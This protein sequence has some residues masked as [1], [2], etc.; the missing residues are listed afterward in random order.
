MPDQEKIPV[1]TSHHQPTQRTVNL[2]VYLLSLVIVFGIGGYLGYIYTPKPNYTIKGA[3]PEQA[4]EYGNV[5][6]E[7]EA[8]PEYLTQDVDF[9][10][11]WDVWDLINSKYYDKNV[12]QT[13]LFYGA[14]AGLVNSLGDPHTVFMT[15]QD[16]DS[17]E[18]ELQGHFEGIGAEIGIRNEQLSVISPLPDHP[19]I[20]AGLRA[21][22]LILQIDGEDTQG[23]SLHEA[24]SKIRGPKGTEVVLTIYRQGLTQPQDYAITRQEINVKSLTLEYQD[25]VGVIKIRQF[26]GDTVPLLNDAILDV[27]SRSDVKGLIVDLRNNPGGYLQAAIEVAGEWI[28]GQT[29]VVEKDRVGNELKHRSNRPARLDNYPTIVLINAG[30]ASGSE[31]LAGAL[32]D[33]G[34]C[35]VVGE[36]S[37]GKGSVQELIYLDN[38]ASVKLTVAKWFTPNGRSIEGNGIQPDFVIEMSEEDYN[39]FQDPQMVKALELLSQ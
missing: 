4:A 14:L 25:K 39:Q 6:N 35:Q 38:D 15:A 33:Y 5:V 26:N 21:K 34:Q 17:F 30:S 27:T 31:I 16:S 13:Q 24:V 3:S 36:T 22:D 9:N 8:I 18:E 10:L 19:A 11:F 28:D 12:P 37:Y 2:K 20:K 32:Q 1:P 29:V 7:D 23:M